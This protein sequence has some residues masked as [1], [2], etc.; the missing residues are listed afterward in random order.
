MGA[1]CRL[2]LR[3]SWQGAVAD[4]RLCWGKAFTMPQKAGKF[5][6]LSDYQILGND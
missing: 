4:C 5:F 6:S 2:I 3:G 1:G